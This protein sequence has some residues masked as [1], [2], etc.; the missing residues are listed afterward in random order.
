MSYVNNH[1]EGF[2]V[3]VSITEAQ[4]RITFMAIRNTAP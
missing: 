1:R 4:L 2:K 3:R